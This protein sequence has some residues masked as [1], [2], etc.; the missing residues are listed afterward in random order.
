MYSKTEEPEHRITFFETLKTLEGNITSGAGMP[1]FLKTIRDE[2]T[3]TLTE[4]DR[5][6]LGEII[7][8]TSTSTEDDVNIKRP[9][10]Q[11]WTLDDLDRLAKSTD[12][13][14][15]IKRGR[16]LFKAALCIRCHRKK[17]EGGLTGPDLT[18]VARRFN[19]RDLLTSILAPSK[20][21]AENYRNV[22]VV[23]KDGNNLIGRVVTG[24]DYRSSILKLATDPLRLSK[25]TEIHKKD[26]ERSRTLPS[27]PMPKGLLNTLTH[28]EIDDL[29]AF[30]L[31]RK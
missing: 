9:V 19:R 2:A 6:Y 7:E 29:L 17:L 4:A 27:S 23:T 28:E 15:D 10:V 18:S 8:P 11:E 24:G 16:E 25:I 1:G 31:D 3:A 13:K 12:R 26:I 14:S 21:V 20:V 5:K 30:L 22:Q